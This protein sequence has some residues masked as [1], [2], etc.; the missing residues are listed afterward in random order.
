MLTREPVTSREYRYLIPAGLLAIILPIVLY[1]LRAL[2]DNRLV[3]WNMVADHVSPGLPLLGILLTI[4]TA[5]LLSRFRLPG[6]ALLFALAFLASSLFWGLPES[7]VDASRYFTQAKHL[8]VYGPTFFLSQWGGQIDAWTDM[9]L[10]SLLYGL[11]FRYLGEV[12]LY[13]Q[14]LNSLLLATTVTLTAL[15]ARE[16]WDRH[17]GNAAGLLL[18]AIPYLFT[19][20]PLLLVDIGAMTFLL[21]AAYLFLLALR[22]GGWLLLFSASLAILLAFLTKYSTWLM[23]SVLALEFF[24]VFHEKRQAAAKRG[25]L[26]ALFCVLLASPV[27]FY[28]GPLI[29]DQ[30]VILWEFQK[31]GLEAWGESFTSTFLFQIHPLLSIAAAGSLVVALFRKDA[32]FLMVAWLVLLLIPGMQVKRIRYLIPIF[33]MLAIMAAYGLSG[34]ESKTLRRFIIY[35]AVLGSLSIGLTAY[36]PFLHTNSLAN[37]QAAAKYLNSMEAETVMVRT[38][39]QQTEL[40]PAVAVP[41]L[42]LYTSKTI[43][44]LPGPIKRPSSEHLS[45]MSLRFTWDYKNP[46]Y[47]TPPADQQADALVIIWGYARPRPLGHLLVGEFTRSEKIYSFRPYVSIFLPRPTEPE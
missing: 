7:I 27:L 38:M 25:G 40:N 47:Y 22:R 8:G 9:P 43:Y 34:L 31:P 10:M 18:L 2:D 42:D 26:I 15:L 32:R 37:L 41:I 28:Y 33:P 12:R 6:P 30:L 36:R 17:I 45:Q 21:L 5:Y 29:G 3:S 4:P 46:G 20:T 11:I 35:C 13:A 19:Q 44:Y 23:L 39:P 1:Q 14:I 16:L 24:L